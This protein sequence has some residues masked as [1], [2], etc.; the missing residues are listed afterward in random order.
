MLHYC[1]GLGLEDL[2]CETPSQMRPAAARLAEAHR[3]ELSRFFKWAMLAACTE[4]SMHPPRLILFCTLALLPVTSSLAA[5]EVSSQTSRGARLCVATVGNASTTSA[6]VERLTERLT[7]SLKQNKV[8]AV[9]MKSPT[10]DKHPLA[11]SPDNG[12]EAKQK[13]CD[14]ILLSQVRDPRQH[15]FE[16]QPPEITIGG[17]VPSVDASD[18]L[19]GSS[20]P[21][22][23]ENLQV[24][25]ALFQLGRFK[26]LLATYVLERPARNV[27][28][29]LL[30]AMDHEANRV[31][32][33]WRKKRL[34]E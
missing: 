27:S 13:E 26:P 7:K 6:F 5:Q 30:P 18:P 34:P 9:T 33:E 14:Y 1:S 12:E 24:D 28:D 11:L 16:Q 15:P 22:Y 29:T 31:A 19:G 10:R 3:L 8:N 2:G 25:F 4:V 21:V 20:G 32:G 23:R 17:R